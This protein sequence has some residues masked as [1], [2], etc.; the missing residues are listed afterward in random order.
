MWE[1]LL[2]YT[3]KIKYYTLP[4]A[5][6]LYSQ[7]VANILGRK[8]V[9]KSGFDSVSTSWALGLQL[10]CQ[11]QSF[12]LLLIPLFFTPLHT[13]DFPGL[14]FEADFIERRQN[15]PGSAEG[16]GS[17]KHAQHRGLHFVFVSLGFV[18]PFLDDIK[19]AL[20][21]YWRCFVQR[22]VQSCGQM[23]GRGS[24][25]L[26]KCVGRTSKTRIRKQCVCFNYNNETKRKATKVAAGVSP[27][28]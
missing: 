1:P 8:A 7:K 26:S 20:I 16:K 17:G 21:S 18:H 23:Q 28:D 14:G 25:V 22:K 13:E 15:T 3:T 24:R 2:S 27:E 19:C 6:Q 5:S 9:T 12:F 10:R 11:D 4:A